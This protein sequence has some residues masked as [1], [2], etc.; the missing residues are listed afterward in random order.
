MNVDQRNKELIV[1]KNDSRRCVDSMVKITQQSAEKRK[2]RAGKRKE[3]EQEAKERRRR[4]MECS[5]FVERI[6][7]IHARL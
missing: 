1:E 6:L 4:D 7:N 5:R 3:Q 2:L